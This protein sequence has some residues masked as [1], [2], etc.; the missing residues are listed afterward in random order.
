M[1]RFCHY[2]LLL[3]FPSPEKA[4]PDAYTQPVPF[5][6]CPAPRGILFNDYD[7]FGGEVAEGGEHCS[8]GLQGLSAICLI[9][10]LGDVFIECL[11]IHD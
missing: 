5:Y 8:G 10:V 3:L 9:L 7:S 4:S 11:A 2:R 1:L 6:T